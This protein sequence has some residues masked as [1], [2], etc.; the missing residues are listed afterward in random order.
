M[1]LSD[2]EL[3]AQLEAELETR[4]E[5]DR[6]AFYAPC[7]KIEEFIRL[8][9]TV[10]D[11]VF[12]LSAAN[13]VGKT[14]ALVNIARSI[15]FGPANK[16]FDYPL[17]R[18]WPYPKRLRFV[19]EPSQVKESGPFPTEIKKWWPRGRYTAQKD[20]QHYE[21]I[22]R[23]GDFILEVMTY[24]QLPKQHEGANLGCVMFNEPPPQ[25]LWTPN[26]SRLR[27]GGI[28]IVGMTP[29]T[30]A[31]W[32]FDEVVPRHEKT[33]VYAGVEDACIIHGVRGHLEHEQIV[34]MG[35]EYS[36]DEREARMGGKAMY[37]KGLV[38][39]SFSY[40]VHVLPEPVRPPLGSTVY[41]VVDPHADKPFFAIWAWPHRNG[42]LY[43]VDEHPN[44]DF[45]RMRNNPWTIEDY[46]RMYAAKEHSYL[47]K[48]VIDRHFAD[49]RSGAYKKTLRDDLA[50]I[51]MNY[52][53][54]YSAAAGEPE[55]DTG[56]LKVREY[57]KY[58]PGKPINSINRPRLY[59]NPHCLNT[60]KAFSRWSLDPKTGD[61]QDAFKDPMDVVRYLVM[62][63]P[64]PSEPLPPQQFKK[65]YG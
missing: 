37:L 33:T 40:R 53:P 27:A 13:G 21:S 43:I 38:Y 7:G 34:K 46:K 63:N 10:P 61:Y 17:F 44:E 5:T 49:V 11:L 42:D 41:N 62:A 51:G 8:V 32:F 57:L 55:I 14:T 31:G 36:P 16:Y 4:R 22:Y 39:K 60:I 1:R 59:I 9:G 28:A 29:L 56:V 12:T 2:A 48:R 19:S 50:A 30:E 35:E 26:M 20:G 23:A 3:L 64:K 18:N 65:L 52:E 58:D 25:S 54:S 6:S 45:F 47:I 24:E 15:M